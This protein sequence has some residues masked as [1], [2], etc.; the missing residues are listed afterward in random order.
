MFFIGL[1]GIA[2]I[3]FLIW[4]LRSDAQLR[5]EAEERQK[6]LEEHEAWERE[7]EAKRE[8]YDSAK[9]AALSEMEEKWGKCTKDIFVDYSTPFAIKDRLFVFEEAEKIVIGGNICDFQDIIGFSLVNNSKAIYNA[10][11]TVRSQK[12]LGNM[13]ARGVAGK[14]IAGDTGAIIGAMSADQ[15]YEYETEFDSEVENEYKIY[16][17]VDSIS[18]PTVILNIGSNE[19]DAYEIANLLNVIIKR[20]DSNE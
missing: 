19:E 16:V 12:N 1:A 6:S 18:T 17:N 4:I 10:Y 2:L 3:V 7:W 14:L 8:A 11:T 5:K 20:N 9:T 15:D 13:V